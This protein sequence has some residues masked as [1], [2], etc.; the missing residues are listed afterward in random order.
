MLLFFCIY[1]FV[2]FNEMNLMKIEIYIFFPVLHHHHHRIVFSAVEIQE[3]LHDRLQTWRINWGCVDGWI[4]ICWRGKR[5]QWMA[6]I[7]G[8][9]LK[10]TKCIN[11]CNW[12]KRKFE[13]IFIIGDNWPI[14]S[15]EWVL[16][17]VNVLVRKMFHK[18]THSEVNYI[19]RIDVSI[20]SMTY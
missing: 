9:I 4:C 16:T 2:F 6:Y 18:H 19:I 5:R 1:F 11:N 8:Q 20:C 17:I 12:R 3:A 15:G 7:S 14:K 10:K 13:Y